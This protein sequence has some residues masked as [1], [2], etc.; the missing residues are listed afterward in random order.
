MKNWRVLV[1]VAAVVLAGAAAYL[2]YEYAHK[3]DTRAEKNVQTVNVLVAKGDIS[4]GTSAAQALDS[5]LIST[6]AI[7]AR[8]VAADGRA[9]RDRPDQQGRGCVDRQGSVHR[10]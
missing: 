4:K 5:G 7:A 10:G 1:A 3:A 9:E 8:R 6:K 2:S